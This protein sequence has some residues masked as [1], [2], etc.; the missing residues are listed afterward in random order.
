MNFELVIATTNEHKVKE[1]REILSPHGITVYSF[2]DLNI[3]LPDV[4]ENGR[5]FT[6]NATIK[7]LEAAKLVRLPVIADDS[8]L[9]IKALKG[10]PGIKTARFT[11]EAGGQ[12]NANQK[13][14]K[15]LINKDH[16]A[17]FK[18]VIALANL[19]DKPLI[20]EGQVDGKIAD[21]Y[22]NEVSFGY[23]PIFIPDGYNKSFH[24]LDHK[25]S[26][27]GYVSNFKGECKWNEAVVRNIID[28]ERRCGKIIAWKTF[29]PSYLDH[30]VK[31]QISH[32]AN[33]CKKLVTMLKIN[34]LI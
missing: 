9:C 3:D 22:L 29:T 21:K 4:N 28:N 15:R 5:T 11:K 26:S 6:K 25:V 1:Y 23:D 34:E 7:A 20:F 27:L 18:C 12:I 24:A 31:N 30:K 32:R 16:S 14:V 13:I 10:F 17:S 2:K 8:G 33:A 19:T